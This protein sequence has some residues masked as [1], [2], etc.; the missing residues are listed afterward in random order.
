MPAAPAAL[1]PLATLP[2]L[3]ELHLTIDAE[4]FDLSVLASLAGLEELSLQADSDRT[5]LGDISF[6]AHLP[7]LKRLELSDWPPMRTLPP[8]AGLDERCPGCGAKRWVYDTVLGP[9]R[10]R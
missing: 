8:L 10:V 5:D 2:A 1:A 4:P 9:W 7:A 6:I 3:R